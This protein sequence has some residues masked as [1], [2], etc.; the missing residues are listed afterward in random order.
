MRSNV[1]TAGKEIVGGDLPC[2]NLI[3]N[4]ISVEIH[5]KLNFTFYRIVMRENWQHSFVLHYFLFFQIRFGFIESPIKTEISYRDVRF[6]AD[7]TQIAIG[8]LLPP[9]LF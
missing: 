3:F 5:S 1:F 6:S 4:I 2:C 7:S 9:V 8:S